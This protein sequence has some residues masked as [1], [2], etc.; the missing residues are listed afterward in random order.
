MKKFDAINECIY[1]LCPNLDSIL[2]LY[3]K[4]SRQPTLNSTLFIDTLSKEDYN[5][6]KCLPI[7][8]A[9]ITKL[10][11]ELFPGKVSTTKPC[12]YLLSEF[13]YK[14]C[15]HC[16]EVKPL[17]D[18]RTNSARKDG[19]NTYCKLCHVAT[20]AETQPHRQSVYKSSK[21]LRTPIWADLEKIK[22]IYNSCPTGMTVDHIVP[23]QGVNVSGLHVHN[24][25]QY[26]TAAENSA[27]NN[28]FLI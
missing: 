14:W 27:K 13:G 20:T 6:S 15:G 25:L 11:K 1:K 3:S 2:E 26:L 4:R 23:L 5:L 16:K 21:L 12:N 22:S 8:A 7:S 10:L 17:H 19:L 9:T 28:R 18:F 24:N